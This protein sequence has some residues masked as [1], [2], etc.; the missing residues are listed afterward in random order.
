VSDEGGEGQSF[1]LGEGEEITLGRD[2]DQSSFTVQDASASRRH[3]T[4][5]RQDGAILLKNE[6]S[7]NG[8]FVNEQ[9]VR[10][11]QVKAGDILRI[12]RSRVSV[13]VPF[14]TDK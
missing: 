5:S 1:T 7:S 10:E 4:I 14:T 13:A 11:I 9:R 8:T 6:G 3:C 12:G 2:P